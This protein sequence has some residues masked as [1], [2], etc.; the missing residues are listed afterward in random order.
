MTIFALFKKPAILVETICKLP[1]N[2]NIFRINYEE[3]CGIGL[4]KLLRIYQR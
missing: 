4:E 1:Y 2:T 3:D